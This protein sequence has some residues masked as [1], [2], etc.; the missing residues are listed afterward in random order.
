MQHLAHLN[1]T[2][3]DSVQVAILGS[4]LAARGAVLVGIEADMLILTVPSALPVGEVVQI[5]AATD[6]L[7]AE[8]TEC[9]ETSENISATLRISYATSKKDL[10]ELVKACG[11]FTPQA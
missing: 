1:L 11:A 9:E 3:A 7:V 5:D 10:K 2:E 8:V 6:T 4:E